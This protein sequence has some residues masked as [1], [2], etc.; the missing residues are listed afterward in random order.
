[1][2]G[3]LD[4]LEHL[5]LGNLNEIDLFH[6]EDKAKKEGDKPPEIKETDFLFDKTHTCPICDT[7][8]KVKTVKNGKARLIGTDLDLRPKH[9]GIDMVKYDVVLCPKCGYAGLTR[10]FKSITG[11]QANLVRENITKGFKGIGEA[12]ESISYE[13]GLD[14]YKMALANAYVKQGR[15]SEKAYICL[16]SAW[17][18]RGWGQS[19][20]PAVPENESRKKEFEELEKEYLKNALEGFTMA[21]QKESFPM[22]G[23]DETTVDY[24]LAVLAMQFEKYD[25]SAKMISGII[26]TPGA[27]PRMK[28]KARDL[29]EM[30]M[31]RIKEQKA[32]KSG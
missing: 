2:V 28:D 5:G 23:M 16:K 7:E 24:L 17:L 29:K 20:D 15:A 21:R 30:I 11:A 31:Q 25:I 12:G 10:Y 4:G 14:R 32:A 22:C 26:G 13:E 18:V 8:F 9:E 1:M 6:K 3:I 27:N 19:L